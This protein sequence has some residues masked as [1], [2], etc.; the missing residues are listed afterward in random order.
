MVAAVELCNRWS[1]RL[2]EPPDLRVEHCGLAGESG[3]P[4]ILSLY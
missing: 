2:L 1:G 3:L 4:L